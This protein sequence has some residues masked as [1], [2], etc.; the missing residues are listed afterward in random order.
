MMVTPEECYA[1]WHREYHRFEG[2]NVRTVK[3]FTKAKDREYWSCFEQFAQM[4]NRNNG[5]INYRLYITALADQYGGYFHPSHLNKR[6]SLKIYKSYVKEKQVSN[7]EETIKKSIWSSLKFMINFCADEKINSFDDYVRHDMYKVPTLLKHLDAGSISPYML[8]CIPNFD[9][10][11]KS[12]PVDVVQEFGQDFVDNYSV[13][14][15]K[16]LHIGDN[17]IKILINNNEREFD[18]LIKRENNKKNN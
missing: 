9:Q 4:V 13:Y 18:R 3:N 6:R 7:S 15:H 10:V 1:H 12:Y 14:R 5:K 16:I 8:A 2:I 17:L 11:F